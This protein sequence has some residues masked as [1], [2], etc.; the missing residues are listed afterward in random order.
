MR[1]KRKLACRN[2][3]N[4]DVYAVRTGPDTGELIYMQNMIMEMELGRKLRSDER[5]AF[6][7][8]NTLD[9][10]RE[11]LYIETAPRQLK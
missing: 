9:C 1:N 6:R 3:E 4:V 8:G 10:R 5:V 2:P 11:N 7:N